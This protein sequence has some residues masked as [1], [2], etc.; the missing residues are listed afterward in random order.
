MLGISQVIVVAL[1]LIARKS[2]G[3]W[4]SLFLFMLSMATLWL[5]PVLIFGPLISFGFVAPA[6]AWPLF[7]LA[8][9]LL[10]TCAMTISDIAADGPAHYLIPILRDSAP[11]HQQRMVHWI[12]VICGVGY[13]LSLIPLG[14]TVGTPKALVVAASAW[15]LLIVPIVIWLYRRSASRRRRLKARKQSSSES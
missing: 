15:G 5:V 13:F 4:L 10:L 2:G 8:D 1:A 11:L 14:L 3:G 6:A 12:G 9:V 7:V